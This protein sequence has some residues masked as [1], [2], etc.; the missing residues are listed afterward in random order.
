MHKNY[1]YSQ[2]KDNRR[3]VVGATATPTWNG[4]NLDTIVNFRS[5]VITGF[6]LFDLVINVG[7]KGL[8]K[9]KI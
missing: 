5:P 8:F 3:K 2:R 6:L 4:R 7:R 9:Y 1:T